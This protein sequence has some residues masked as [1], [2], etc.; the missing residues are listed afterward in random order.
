MNFISP[1]KQNC[2]RILDNSP[3]IS[4]E[5]SGRNEELLAGLLNT[6]ETATNSA[7]IECC[8]CE[9]A[10]FLE[11]FHVKDVNDLESSDI[12]CVVLKAMDDNLS[13]ST[14][15]KQGLFVLSRLVEL[16]EYFKSELQCQD[17]HP[18]ILHV[19]GNFAQD[20]CIQA[21]GCKLMADL[22]ESQTIKED[23]VDGGAVSIIFEAVKTFTPEEELQI[24]ALRALFKLLEN[25]PLQQQKFV[26]RG[27]FSGVADVVKFHV[28]SGTV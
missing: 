1:G 23:L 16:S 22:V 12:H 20:V 8:M 25:D 11:D 5:H 7:Q 10:E 4:M 18:F 24:Y 21:L 14:V 6:I 9:L 28:N 13:N 3:G 27:G 19:I 17:E 26:S 15:H 2:F